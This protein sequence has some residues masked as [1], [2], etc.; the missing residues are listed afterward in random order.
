MVTALQALRQHTWSRA[1]AVSTATVEQDSYPVMKRMAGWF[2]GQ[3]YRSRPW[4]DFGFGG[5]VDS[6]PYEKR[7]G[8]DED[9][10]GVTPDGT[11]LDAVRPFMRG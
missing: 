4:S 9:E 11:V 3:L 8:Q 2:D 1:G 10:Y 6:T 5:P 7:F